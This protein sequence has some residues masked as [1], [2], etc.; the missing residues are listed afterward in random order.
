MRR[1]EWI[2]RHV[3]RPIELQLYAARGQGREGNE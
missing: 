2:Q 3:E 1:N